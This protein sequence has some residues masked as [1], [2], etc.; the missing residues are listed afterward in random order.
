MANFYI[1]KKT[2][3]LKPITYTWD[4]WGSIFLGTEDW[5][6]TNDLTA[7]GSYTWD[8]VNQGGFVSSI[9][10]P[11]LTFTSE[12]IDLGK[13]THVNP[14]TQIT[15]DGN[16]GSVYGNGIQVQVFAA[17]AIDSSSDLSV[18]ADQTLD[19]GNPDLSPPITI[20]QPLQGRYFQYKVSLY[21]NA[22]C[23]IQSVQTKLHSTLQHEFITADTSSHE[24]SS[25][26]RI[27][28]LNKKF[29]TILAINAHMHVPQPFDSTFDS[30]SHTI[31]PQQ[32]GQ[33]LIV[34]KTDVT[35]PRYCVV[36]SQGEYIDAEVTFHV[37]GLP[38]FEFNGTNL[39]LS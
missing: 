28:P 27:L 35:Y 11:S 39:I 4:Q 19:T 34:D 29:S 30:S 17:N 7:L 36:N 8:D 38:Q 3:K 26:A 32:F 25:V 12:I 31:N 20:A 15:T 24:G 10:F 13:I 2:G 21:G 18:Q 9:G 37:I 33:V 16:Q 1:D 23:E 22:F 6:D 5:D 14:L